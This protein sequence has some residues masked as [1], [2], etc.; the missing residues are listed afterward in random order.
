M[1]GSTHCKDT[2]SCSEAQREQPPLSF[3]HQLGDRICYHGHKFLQFP[4]VLYVA[5]AHDFP[6]HS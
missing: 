4:I 6:H 2:Y 3:A 5:L 1:V